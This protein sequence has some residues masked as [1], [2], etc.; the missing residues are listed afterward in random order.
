MLIVFEVC[1]VNDLN[2]RFCYCVVCFLMMMLCV[3]EIESDVVMDDEIV[4]FCVVVF[5]S[6][7]E[8]DVMMMME[9]LIVIVIKNK[10]FVIE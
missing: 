9:S 2:F 8:G 1:F 6:D 4:L 7:V 10:E 3:M 5:V